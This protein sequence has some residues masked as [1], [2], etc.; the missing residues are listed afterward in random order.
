MKVCDNADAHPFT[1]GW[2]VTKIH[3]FKKPQLDVRKHLVIQRLKSRERA[4]KHRIATASHSVSIAPHQ[5]DDEGRSIDRLQQEG[6]MESLRPLS[7]VAV[8]CARCRPTRLRCGVSQHVTT[9]T[10]A[11]TTEVTRG[12]VY[13]RVHIRSG[14]APRVILQRVRDWNEKHD[15]TV[16]YAARVVEKR[17]K[18]TQEQQAEEERQQ[19]Q[20]ENWPS[21]SRSR[22]PPS[23]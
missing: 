22:T 17:R 16:K 4:K 5:V 11:Q 18:K 12:A 6:G 2:T 10:K 13:T 8:P 15:E 7:T 14:I 1:S 3:C 20:V 23:S 19:R 21:K 9:K